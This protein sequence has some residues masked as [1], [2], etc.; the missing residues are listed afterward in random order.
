M[1]SL[2]VSRKKMWAGSFISFWCVLGG[3]M[4]EL[5]KHLRKMMQKILKGI[6]TS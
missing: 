1:R 6:F 5:K 4:E 3:T 2:I